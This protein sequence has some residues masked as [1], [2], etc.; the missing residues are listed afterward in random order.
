MNRT[1]VGAAIGLILGLVVVL[2]GFWQMLVVA[3]FT[4]IGWAVA[5]VVS[6]EL[7]LGDLNLSLQRRSP[8]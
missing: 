7:D 2:V 6:G 5:K 4:V 8:R 3:L 1:T